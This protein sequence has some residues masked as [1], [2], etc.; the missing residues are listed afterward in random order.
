MAKFTLEPYLL[1]FGFLLPKSLRRAKVSTYAQLGTKPSCLSLSLKFFLTVFAIYCSH[2]SLHYSP[3]RT[4]SYPNKYVTARHATNHGE[5]VASDIAL[6]AGE[7]YDTLLAILGGRP[8]RL[9]LSKGGNHLTPSGS[10]LFF[11]AANCD[12][13]ACLTVNVQQKSRLSGFNGY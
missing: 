6:W 7:T 1:C 2:L 5:R 8:C 13:P 9:S 3:I 10:C 4:G 12:K 11:S